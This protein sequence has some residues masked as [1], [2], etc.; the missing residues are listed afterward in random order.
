MSLGAFPLSLTAG[1]CMR[2]FLCP[3][4]T[5]LPTPIPLSLLPPSTY[6]LI[7]HPSF[8]Y[9]SIYPLSI[10]SS[11][12]L[13]LSCVCLSVC[14]SFAYLNIHHLFVCQSIYH[15]LFVYLFIV[16]LGPHLQHMEV[17]RL[18]VELEPAYATATATPDPSHAC[19]LHCSSWQPWIPN[20]LSKARDGTHVHGY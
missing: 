2:S 9:L 14:L 16:F 3:S 10:Y 19:D 4:T 15:L 5:H 11:T 7:C 18:G 12:H 13:H 20:P 6:P 17:R 1:D 8:I